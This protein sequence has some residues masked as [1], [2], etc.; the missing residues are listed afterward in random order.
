ML[1]RVKRDRGE[2]PRVGVD[3]GIL[4]AQTVIDITDGTVSEE[5]RKRTG[6]EWATQR[7]MTHEELA[8][9]EATDPWQPINPPQ[10]W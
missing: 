5:A 6:R 3:P 4:L 7:G 2:L 8:E 10:V 1:D 9:L